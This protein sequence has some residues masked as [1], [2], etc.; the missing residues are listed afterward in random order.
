MG[1]PIKKNILEKHPELKEESF[2]TILVDG[3]NLLRICFADD[4]INSNG[5]H[6]GAT[7]QFL[8]Q[9]REV[10]KKAGSKLRYVYVV[11]D[12]AK[13]GLNRYE[14]WPF[15]KENRDKN[16]ASMKNTEELGEYGK[17][18]EAKLRSMQK[19]LFNKN[20]PKREKSDAEKF[21]D[22]N[23]DRE[24]DLL[25]KYFNELYIRWIFNDEDSSE[26]DDYI[27][28]YVSHKKPCE[29]IIIMSTDEDITQLISDSVCV[30]NKKMGVYLSP[31]N[32][33]RLK[34]YDVNNV[35]LKKIICG[36]S[37][38]NI[39][40]VVGVSETRLYELV[41]E[42][43]ERKVTLEEVKEKAQKAIDERISE[44]KKPLKWHENIVNGVFNGEYDGDLYEIN[45]K[46]IDLRENLIS[47]GGKEEIESMMYAVQDPEG[48][49][50][51]NLYNFI[52]EDGIDEL[53]NEK[54]FSAFFE[55]FKALVDSEV[56]RYKKE[57][58]K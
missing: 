43:K 41:P 46:I 26:G 34:G 16:Y 15:Y 24:R 54:K 38:D 53:K 7:F 6:Y 47:S 11:F 55:P 45:K 9:L 19:Y 8:L 31:K 22:A 44:K 39:K 21:V 37:S 25:L 1:Q 14:Y 33:T 18:F 48:R 5:L 35:V 17:A 32:F 58:G 10:I 51:E 40:N 30:Y 57:F 12:G 20:K 52:V 56:L 23:F 36:D 28:Y 29:N 3:T 2:I 27:S 42:I 13:S 4:K 49:S 50:F